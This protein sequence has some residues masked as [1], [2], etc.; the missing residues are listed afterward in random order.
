MASAGLWWGRLR[1]KNVT[2]VAWND[3]SMRPD[4]SYLADAGECQ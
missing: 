2:H 1:G 4:K 3:V